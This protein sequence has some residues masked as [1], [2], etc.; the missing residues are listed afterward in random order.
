MNSNKIPWIWWLKKRNF[1]FF[2]AKGAKRVSKVPS[3]TGSS[4]GFFRGLEMTIYSEYLYTVFL[5]WISVSWSPLMMILI[6][7][8]EVQQQN[9][10]TLLTFFVGPLSTFVK[11]R[12]A[13]WHVNLGDRIQP[14]APPAQYFHVHLLTMVNSGLARAYLSFPFYILKRNFIHEYYI[15]IISVSPNIPRISQIHWPLLFFKDLFIY[16]MYMSTL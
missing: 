10:S 7:L 8:D 15:Y 11:S 12:L 13:L 3:R 16:F 6:W 14:W 2:T 4:R 1:I 5:I 9:P